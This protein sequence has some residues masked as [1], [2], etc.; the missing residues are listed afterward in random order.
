MSES[1]KTVV[2]SADELS[3]SDDSQAIC[4][5]GKQAAFTIHDCNVRIHACKMSE[6]TSMATGSN[7]VQVT[8]ITNQ[9]WEIPKHRGS[10][11]ACS[12]DYVAYILQGKSGYMLRVI[13]P[14]TTN[15]V[16]LKCAVSDIICDISF[17]HRDSNLLA[18]VDG[19]GNLHVW[20]LEK[21]KQNIAT[22]QPDALKLIIQHSSATDDVE[23]RLTWCPYVCQEDGDQ[24]E[25]ALILAISHGNNIEAVDLQVLF[26]Q[27]S[28]G[29]TVPSD[30]VADGLVSIPDAHQ[31]TITDLSM[32]PDGLVLASS[33][34]DGHLKFWQID[35][36]NR[37][38]KCLHDYVPHNGAPVTRLIFCD[39]HT[40]RDP[41]AQFWRF[42]ITAAND[43]SEVKLWC[44]IT[45]KCL[46]TISFLPPVDQ[47]TESHPHVLLSLDHS[48]K[49][50]L[51]ADSH[52]MVLYILQLFQD[53][54][55][56][57]ASFVSLTEY[58]LT[59]PI[60]S[61]VVVGSKPLPLEES[62]D[63]LDTSPIHATEF[64][65]RRNGVVLNLQCIQT[66]SMQEMHVRFEPPDI[67]G[68]P[69]PSVDLTLTDTQAKD[70][71]N[72]P[73]PHTS[74]GPAEQPPPSSLLPSCLP[75]TSHPFSKT[76]RSPPPSGCSRRQIWCPPRLSPY[77]GH[78]SSP[79]ASLPSP[80][81][82]C[83]RPPPPYSTL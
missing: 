23:H 66:K 1:G 3:R 47:P 11:V 41:S 16:L 9:A 62:G 12:K 27:Y 48:A 29:M 22:A 2:G 71:V 42:L 61:F 56:G 76:L 49:Y 54:T 51:V 58:P 33:S 35:W 63:E 74:T 77:R 8:T 81:W 83:P 21:T 6:A 4:L 43:S 79:P 17:M 39:N 52:R 55:T 78:F 24:D 31:K 75:P 53:G 46:Q 59:Q 26:K 82:R 50:L 80:K 70:V 44:T 30:R 25:P 19:G 13:Q 7:K 69:P 40:I 67:V 68:I 65:S 45:W 64:D 72:L 5:S 28:S 73:Q 57:D 37:T 10:M 60:I 32:S 34:E 36:E 15:R 14:S 38:H 18:C 20:D